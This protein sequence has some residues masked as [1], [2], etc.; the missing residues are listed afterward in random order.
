M[1]SLTK[2][3]SI[4]LNEGGQVLQHALMGL[5]WDA[6]KRGFFATLLK[7]R[8]RSID[9]DASALMFDQAGNLVDAVWFQQLESRD[10]SILHTGDN[11]SGAGEGDDEQIRVTLP[12]VPAEVTTI[13]FLVTCFTGQ[14]FKEVE[15]AF[16]RLLDADSGTEVARYQLADAGEHTAQVMARLKR[17]GDHWSFTAIGDAANGQTFQDLLPALRSY[18]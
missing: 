9:L 4:D 11:V 3:Q 7:G 16:C 8:Q 10:G 17:I 2:G 6:K 13:V 1:V 14:T 15:N 5:G 12:A 18:L